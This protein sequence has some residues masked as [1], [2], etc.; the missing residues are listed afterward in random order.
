MMMFATPRSRSR[1]S[2]RC[3]C[4]AWWWWWWWWS[5]PKGTSDPTKRKPKTH[6]Q[7][8]ATIAHTKKGS[9]DQRSA[10]DLGKRDRASALLG[11][12]RNDTK[13]N[14]SYAPCREPQR[15]V[16]VGVSQLNVRS[17]NWQINFKPIIKKTTTKTSRERRQRRWQRRRQQRQLLDS[18]RCL[19]LSSCLRCVR[20]A[21]KNL[22]KW[23][24]AT[25]GERKGG[26][27]CE[28]ERE[29]T[30]QS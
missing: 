2:S 9:S 14:G 10:S 12:E 29:S 19:R 18:L 16:V 1:S 28:G 17:C 26:R 7:S 30:L 21:D 22:C 3:C 24:P 13:R 11:T 20:C 4:S 5:A 23:E 25:G 6:K 15:R 27:E 8:A